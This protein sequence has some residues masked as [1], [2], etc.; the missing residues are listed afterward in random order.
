MEVILNENPNLYDAVT[1]ERIELGSTVVVTDISS[2]KIARGQGTKIIGRDTIVW[3]AEQAGL[4]VVNGDQGDSGYA[5][6]VDN[7]D[8][9][10][11][12]GEVAVGE[13]KAGG[14]R[15]DKRSNGPVK[16]K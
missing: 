3:L 9:G 5:A 8:V 7:E 16:G 2:R 6:S 14:K 12:N 13:V 4:R 10:V 1:G 15:A 11:G